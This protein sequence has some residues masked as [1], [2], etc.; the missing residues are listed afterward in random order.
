MQ[1][2]TRANKTTSA[3]RLNPAVSPAAKPLLT[4]SVAAELMWSYYRVNKHLLISTIRQ[5]REQIISSLM[6]VLPSTRCSNP[7]SSRSS[8]PSPYA[9][10]RNHALIRRVPRIRRD[11][12]P[13]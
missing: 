12:V 8:Q 10:P 9:K 11:Y 7:S 3:V 6:L 2:K 1:S 4:Y 13:T 5:H